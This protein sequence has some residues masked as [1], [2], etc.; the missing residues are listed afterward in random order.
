MTHANRRNFAGQFAR[1]CLSVG[2]LIAAVLPPAT[3]RAFGGFSASA[4]PSAV[5]HPASDVVLLREGTHTVMTV[6]PW[7]RGPAAPLVLVLPVEPTVTLRSV[8]TGEPA[9]IEHIAALSA[10][11]LVQ[12]YE[13]DPCSSSTAAL[14]E[15]NPTE[16]PTSAPPPIDYQRSPAFTA[17]HAS[18]PYSFSLLARPSASEVLSALEA[19]HVRA[20]DGLLAALA[21]LVRQHKSFLLARV[22]VTP[23]Q[24]R[25]DTSRAVRLTP[26]RIE[27]ESDELTVP[28]RLTLLQLGPLQQTHELNLYVLSR[29]SRYEASQRPV[30]FALTNQ[31][32]LGE[33]QRSFAGFYQAVLD[34][35]FAAQPNIVLT[36][37]AWASTSCDPCP[38]APLREHDLQ[39]L[40][41]D[42]VF[43]V[44][45]SVAWAPR[46]AEP[47]V[48]GGLTVEVARA[49]SQRGL[50]A[51][52]T[53][54]TAHALDRAQAA[55]GFRVRVH[56]G[57]AGRVS[58]A[59]LTEHALSP[60]VAECVAQA[61][62]QWVYPPPSTTQ[63]AIVEQRW[64]LSDL[65]PLTGRFGSFVLTRLRTRLS[66]QSPRHEL[67]LHESAAV[68]GGR[69][70]R[71]QRGVL[72]VGAAT[73]R[74]GNAFQ[75]R[76]VVRHPWTGAIN[77]AHPRRGSF[78][79]REPDT[80]RVSAVDLAEPLVDVAAVAHAQA[81]IVPRTV[82]LSSE[83]DTDASAPA[84]SRDASADRGASAVITAAMD[85]TTRSAVGC[86]V[87]STLGHRAARNVGLCAAVSL[88]IARSCRRT[89]RLL[90]R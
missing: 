39:S 34:R 12:M 80:G 67:L 29:Q 8:R 38:I 37:Y 56:V 86:A 42:A 7:Y 23:A 78:A 46:P 35:Q 18:T 69:E 63:P 64:T 10:P 33:A 49:V 89:R 57:A 50:G 65:S 16:P 52:R 48:N 54:I 79:L 4:S 25:S 40:G 21:P 9:V 32:L 66:P 11:R 58:R 20:P 14:D 44:N 72:E 5:A 87:G 41:A 3:A 22:N 51:I 45:G 30:E 70:L 60:L 76:F 2:A 85:H 31:T 74:W 53:C 75:T 73:S 84:P 13:Q 28:V 88:L 15:S 43:G 68:M 19:A 47:V 26:I 27:F 77:C 62:S 90:A 36:E 83:D 55:R 59:V 81:M 82:V 71:D 17:P 24:L 1:R 61:V 6:A